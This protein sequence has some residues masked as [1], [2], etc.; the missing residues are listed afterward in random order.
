MKTETSQLPKMA[1]FE[2]KSKMLSLKCK[3][4][5]CELSCALC[6]HCVLGTVTSH[7]MTVNPQTWYL[8]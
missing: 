6:L 8:L 4:N 7:S 5:R 3:Q 1:M 2:S